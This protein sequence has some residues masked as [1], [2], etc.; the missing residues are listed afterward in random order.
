MKKILYIGLEAPITHDAHIVHCPLIEIVPRPSTC[1]EI[2]C[3][4]SKLPHTTHVIVTSKTAA[5][6]ALL[7]APDLIGTKSF[8]SVGK[9]TTKTLESFGITDIVTAKTE[10]QEGIIE[11]IQQ[12][13]L[14]SSSFFWGHSSLSRPLLSDFLKNNGFPLT[15]CILYDTVRKPPEQPI[16]LDEID[17]IFFSSPS[18]VEA[19]CFFFGCLP[20]NKILRAQGA[21]TELAIKQRL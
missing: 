4:L 12:K 9:A 16:C 6:C 21:I 7:L 3:A 15:E 17:E 14:F 1:P 20:K 10:S 13:K 18:T 5:R 8:L 11:C 2:I 19:F